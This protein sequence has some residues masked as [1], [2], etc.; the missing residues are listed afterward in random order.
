MSESVT[1]IFMFTDL[2]GSTRMRDRLGDDV[3]DRLSAGHDATVRDALRFTGG[4]EVKT[5]GDGVMAVFESAAEAVA[6]AVRIQ[7][8]MA[9][10]NA[11]A[12]ED[13]RTEVRIGINTGEVVRQDGDY[14]GLPV[15]VAS[16]VCNAAEGGQIVTTDLVRALVG[17][18][19]GFKFAPLGA[20]TL[21]G[22]QEPIDLFEVVTS[23]V[24]V[25]LLGSLEVHLNGRP[26]E[27]DE[28]MHEVL[29]AAL[30]LHANQTVP[31][32]RLVEAIWG[33]DPPS[34]ALG[35]VGYHISE[36]RDLLGDAA[37]GLT[38]VSESGDYR[39]DVPSRSIDV[40]T[41]DS[42]VGEGRAALTAGLFEESCQT[43]DSAILLWAWGCFGRLQAGGVRS[44]R[45]PS[46]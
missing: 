10:V 36:L 16:R 25:A 41:F 32:D 5:L 19:G 37:E 35:T 4:T 26:V 33:D 7:E 42:L 29:F 2:V 40:L 12:L 3:A 8:A 38:I 34:S 6:C 45:H 21:K 14:A 13:H 9:A 18:R 23:F 43:L 46:P 30:A 28:P 31:A 1:A 22:V 20:R 15:A 11:S 39:L 27:L 24:N 44:G 17:T